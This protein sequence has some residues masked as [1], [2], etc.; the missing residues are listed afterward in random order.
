MTHKIIFCLGF[1]LLQILSYAQTKDNMLN[2][3]SDI[4]DLFSKG[5]DSEEEQE[6]RPK[7]NS[8]QDLFSGKGFGIDTSYYVMGG[9]LPGWREAPWYF[10]SKNDWTDKN[11]AIV[12]A[13]MNANISLDI[14][15][16]RFLRIRQTVSF[17]I[18]SPPLTIKE[19]FFDYNF[20]DIFYVKAGKYDFNWGYSP[21]F[22]Y[23]NLLSRIPNGINNPG[24]AYLAK[25]D[26]PIGIG[27]LQLVM[28]TRSGFIEDISKPR[29]ENF[30]EGIKYNIAKEN[31]DID[32][33]GFYLMEANSHDEI[34]NMPLRV[35]FSL[36]T[37]MF[38]SLEFYTEGMMSI[39]EITYSY[40]L[41]IIQSMFKDKL[42]IN[43]EMY[44]NGEGNADSLR[45]NNLLIEDKET[46][47]LLDGF[48]FALNMQFKP[49]L[50]GRFQIFASC[51]YSMYT[52]TAQLVPGITLEPAE[53]LQLYLAVPMALGNRGPNTYYWQNADINNRPFAIVLAIKINGSYRYGHF[54]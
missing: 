38:S 47:P 17:A 14:Q 3:N 15:P 13:S 25:I 20:M 7:H 19:F 18:P 23:A 26:V 42:W 50:K 12:G 41:G 31:F 40:S 1:I 44:Y 8:L 34:Y 54:E 27:G 10:E 6:K 53:H 2:N 33:G 36:K 32:I 9:F 51:L 11:T 39:P 4:N 5:S 29:L 28:L 49:G 45:R 43:A 37:T 46:F 35:F 16:S 21:N 22:P 48:N 24:E 52:N 30:G